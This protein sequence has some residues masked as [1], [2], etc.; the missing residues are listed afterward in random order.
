[1]GF[2]VTLRDEADNT[3]FKEASV[4]RRIVPATCAVVVGSA[5]VAAPAFAAGEL[6]TNGGFEADTPNG[7]FQ[8]T[9][10][11]TGW[12]ISTG[13]VDLI[14]TYW[15]SHTGINSIDL[16]GCDTAI[17]GQPIATIAGT[18]YVLSFWIAGNPDGGGDTVRRAE[19]NVGTTPGGVEVADASANFDTAG[20]TKSNMGWELRTVAF[21]ASTATTYI[22]FVDTNETNQSTC[23]GIALD[24]ISVMEA[25]VVP[26]IPAAASI[27]ALVGVAGLMVLGG[28]RIRKFA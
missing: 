5:L 1:M 25:A 3:F 26:Q 28:R 8:Q 21:T 6:V 27:V 16:K 15:Q 12:T 22:S 19:V 9:S 10:S 7:P 14:G 4:F 20:F 2:P 13:N 11:L 23:R 18:D 24:D 17:V